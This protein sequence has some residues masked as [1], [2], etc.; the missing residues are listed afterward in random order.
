M[1]SATQQR[2]IL[3]TGA[4]KGIGFEIVKKLAKE[5]SENKHLILL[6]SRDLK[7]GEDALIKSGSPS[8]VHLLHL[9]VSSKE[10]IILAVEEIKCKYG[11]ELDIVINNAAM[12][13]LDLTVDVARKMFDTNYYGIKVLNDLL[14]SYLRQNGRIINVTSMCGPIL[15]SQVSKELQEKYLSTTLIFDELDGLVEDFITAIGTNNIEDLGYNRNT[16]FLLYSVTKAAVIILT[17]IEARCW[18][19]DKNL[20]IACVCPGFCSTDLN[21]NAPG[22]RPPEMGAD[23]ILYLMNTPQDQLENG[24]FYRDGQLKPF[25][26]EQ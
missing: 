17:R 21:K 1:S 14:L 9:D 18:S 8:N 5:S 3:V 20:F 16:A 4:N 15:L 22:G 24:C 7:K 11:G 12:G 2:V 13:E 25:V 19:K 23:S 6:G 10:S 26:Y